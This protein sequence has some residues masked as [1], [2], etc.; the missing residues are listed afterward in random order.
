MIKENYFSFK[1]REVSELLS[2]NNLINCGNFVHNRENS[3]LKFEWFI[4]HNTEIA[5]I[6]IVFCFILQR[7]PRRKFTKLC[8]KLIFY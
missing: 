3:F 4:D 1:R 5:P 2:K 6:I 7:S 8:T